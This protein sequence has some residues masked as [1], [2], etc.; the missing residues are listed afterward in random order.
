MGHWADGEWWTGCRQTK[1]VKLGRYLQHIQLLQQN[2]LSQYCE[3]DESLAASHWGAGGCRQLVRWTGCW[4]WGTSELGERS[5]PGAREGNLGRAHLHPE[6]GARGL[7]HAAPSPQALQG[8]WCRWALNTYTHLM[9]LVR[10]NQ[11][12]FA[13]PDLAKQCHYHVELSLWALSEYKNSCSYHVNTGNCSLLRA[14]I[15]LR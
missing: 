13:D 3:I 9:L 7:W 11:K 14:T 15:F 12:H 8:S 6:E 2:T 5:N 1:A 10:S 4:A